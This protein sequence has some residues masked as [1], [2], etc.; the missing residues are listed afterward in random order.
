MSEN[1]SE[2]WRR[3]L[4]GSTDHLLWLHLHREWEISFIALCRGDGVWISILQLVKNR[5]FVSRSYGLQKY[6]IKRQATFQAMLI[7]PNKYSRAFFIWIKTF[8]AFSWNYGNTLLQLKQLLV[9]YLQIE[10]VWFLLWLCFCA[11][12][13]YTHQHERIITAV[14]WEST[15]DVASCHLNLSIS[16]RCVNHNGSPVATDW[17]FT[18]GNGSNRKDKKRDTAVLFIR[19]LKA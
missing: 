17:A 13:L 1:L 2:V 5:A 4:S 6:K 11:T 10:F 16:R 19:L 18:S 8:S 3:F 15:P 14:S 7:S 12:Q 9:P